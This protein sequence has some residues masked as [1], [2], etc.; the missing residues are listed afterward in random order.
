M[1]TLHTPEVDLHYETTGEGRPVL[2]IHGVGVAGQ[3]WRPQ[4]DALASEC[5]AAF[6]DNRG[7]GR[8][9]PCRGP[10]RIEHM[11]RDARAIMDFL[12]WDSA[13][14]VGHSMGGVIAQQ[15]ALDCPSRVRSLALLCTFPSGR[16]A[17]RPTP[18]VLWMALRTRLGTR[19]MRR[20]AFLE[21]ILPKALLAGGDRDDLARRMANHIG[22]DLAHQPPI[23]L[24][25]LRALA[26]HDCRERLA[27]LG[28]IPTLVVS[29][30]EDR[31]APPRFGRELA[32]RIPNATFE[33]I[34][35][36]AHAVTIHDPETVNRRLAAFW[37]EVEA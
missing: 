11:A 9:V 4:T 20:D 29:G 17:A 22:R 16:D 33:V 24:Q 19:R 35:R 36:A 7:L 10:I 8:S 23:L 32:R 13:R 25:Q 3:A 27:E 30:D 18:W 1:P 12:Q 37:R 31:I 6:F 34:P 21:M 14:V 2:F 28:S 26:R 15:L 5:H